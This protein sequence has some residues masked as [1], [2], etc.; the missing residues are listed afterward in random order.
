MT[1]LFSVVVPGKK[2]RRVCTAA[3]YNAKH[4]QCIC[5]C[6]GINHQKGLEGAVKNTRELVDVFQSIYKEV[7]F[8][9]T[10]LQMSLDEII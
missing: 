2:R 9:N 1:S 8:S 6:N 4:L 10:V 3:C 5:V 7:N